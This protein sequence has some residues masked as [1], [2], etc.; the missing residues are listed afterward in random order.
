M[1]VCCQASLLCFC[2]FDW[3]SNSN[4]AACFFPKVQREA[5]TGC[6]TL[7]G[8]AEILRVMGTELCASSKLYTGQKTAPVDPVL[9]VRG[10][11]SCILNS[12]LYGLF[13][14]TQLWIGPSSSQTQ[15][16]RQLGSG[17]QTCIPFSTQ[18]A[19]GCPAECVQW[20]KKHVS[21][22]VIAK[23]FEHSIHSP[24]G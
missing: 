3:F 2:V 8:Y 16:C 6:L 15:C 1:I 13:I 21:L 14:V 24:K 19:P 17:Y 18:N 5:T 23:V 7:K 4:L 10:Q 20:W 9:Q 22:S 12:I 11:V